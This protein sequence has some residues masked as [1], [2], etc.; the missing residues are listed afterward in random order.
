MKVYVN[1][2]LISHNASCV[3]RAGDRICVSVGA[4]R[5][6]GRFAAVAFGALAYPPFPVRPETV[7]WRFYPD[8]AYERAFAIM[9]AGDPAVQQ[10]Y[11]AAVLDPLEA[12]PMLPRVEHSAA[13]C[14]PVTRAAVPELRHAASIRRKAVTAPALS[15]PAL[16]VE[17]DADGWATKKRARTPQIV[18]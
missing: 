10:S 5:V 16:I 9:A 1:G 18:D 4:G 12:R 14:H 2:S 7:C 11:L 17:L 8:S 3:L 13:C 15:A 6:R